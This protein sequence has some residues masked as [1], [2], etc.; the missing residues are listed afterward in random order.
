MSAVDQKTTAIGRADI[1]GDRLQYLTFLLG[2]QE[3]GVDIL[4]VQEIK[5]WDQ[6][7]RVPSTPAH[8]KGVINLRG[9]IVPV[10]DLRLRLGLDEIPYGA[11]TVIVIVRIE[12]PRGQ[13]TTGLVVDAVADVFTIARA[14]LQD[15]P[16]FGAEADVKYIE[17]VA[18]R[19]DTMLIALALDRLL[20]ATE[21]D[22]L[23]RVG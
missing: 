8:V 2:E 3:Y 21:L 13:R 16:D 4:R 6:V 5:G 23:A 12:T 10:I 17:G 18:V 15:A 14:D 19:G 11:T 20:S 7:T 9:S 22:A 1:G